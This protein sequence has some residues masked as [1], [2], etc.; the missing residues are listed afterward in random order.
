MLGASTL[1]KVVERSPNIQVVGGLLASQ[2]VFG[3][4]IG[5]PDFEGP[6]TQDG[7]VEAGRLQLRLA[8]QFARLTNP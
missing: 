6:V 3:L 7:T 8:L 2:L 1:M 5:Q 4:S